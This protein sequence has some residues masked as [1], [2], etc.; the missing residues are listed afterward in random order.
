M[1]RRL[2][3]LCLALVTSLVAGCSG[4][5]TACGEGMQTCDNACI[6]LGAAC[7]VMGDMGMSTQDDMLVG[8]DASLASLSVSPGGLN[9]A[10]SPTVTTYT[11][12]APLLS[13]TLTVTAAAID[14]QATI[15]VNGTVAVGGT[16]Q[17]TLTPGLTMILVEVTSG[18][19][20]KMSYTLAVVP[21]LYGKASNTGAGDQFG[22]SMSLSGDTLAVGAPYESSNATGIGGDQ[23]NNTSTS[24]GAVYVFTR[25]GGSWAQQ[26]YIKASNTGPAAAFGH[27]LSLSGDTLAV[28]AYGEASNATG[29]GGNQNNTMATGSGAVYVFARTGTV[30]AQQAYIKASNTGANDQFGYSVSLAGDT[31]AVGAPLEDSNATGIDGNGANNTA[32]DSGAAYV[33][34]RTGTTWAQQAYVKASN[35]G[36]M[37]YFGY[38]VSLSGN[39]LAVGAYG[40]S[41]N[42]T[43]IGGNQGDNTSSF[44]GAAYVFTRSGTTWTQ[45]AY[46][47]AS[48]TD[49]VDYFGYSVS[50][51]GDTLAV[52][53]S[54]EDSNATGVG[55]AQGDNTV[56]D[57]GAVY[58]FTR[59]G[60]TWSQ[61]AYLKA[62][63]TGA[64]DYF[65]FSVSLSG[66]ML[67]VGAYGEDSNATG[68]G[69]D[70][71]NNSIGGSGAA[72]LFTRNGTTWSQR[73]YI[74]A[75][76]PGNNDYF[77]YGLSLSAGALAVGAYGEASNATGFLGDQ[78]NN[79]LASSGAVYLFQ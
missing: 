49:S 63:N 23:T 8:S 3:M 56:A 58:V 53:A 75:S 77:G 39:T 5:G 4:G 27:S 70:G 62:S 13:N 31:L 46:V 29:V 35:T 47:K 14:A 64:S 36:M 32:T 19:G 15:R 11:V 60:T 66:D 28:G 41:S 59:S 22:W 78:S 61:Q 55:G 17:V 68:I 42:A 69:G 40:E 24:S 76:N 20:V 9:P 10:F 51:S 26:A 21:S 73:A 72:Y 38:S 44:A 7:T 12:T 30:W 48:N 65:G 79:S 37:D 45:Q 74:K 6:P 16:A 52:G 57:S 50:L 18:T 54:F 34:T 25:V 43:G 67:A 2:A 33:F 71:S 1:Q